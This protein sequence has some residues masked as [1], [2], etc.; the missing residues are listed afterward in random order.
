MTKAGIW[1]FI[2]G[3]FML[4][5]T[6]GIYTPVL[7]TVPFWILAAIIYLKTDKAMADKIFANK[8]YGKM[9]ED[10][11]VH[12]II[13][14]KSKKIALA[15]LGIFG[16]ISAFITYKIFWLFIVQ[17]AAMSYGAWFVATRPESKEIEKND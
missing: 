15:G 16:I 6:W 2:A 11:V 12:G 8:Q 13:T 17:I 1:K 3:G 4:L 9:V 10:F 5:G 14:A 7:P